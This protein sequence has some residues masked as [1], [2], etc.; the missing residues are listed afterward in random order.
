MTERHTMNRKAT[1]AAATLAT[2]LVPPAGSAEAHVT[3]QPAQAPAGGFARLDVRVPSEDPTNPT[4]KVV[5]QM[6]PGFA[7]ASY[8][9]VPGWKVTVATRKLATPIKTDDGDTLTDELSRLTFTATGHG[10]APGQFQDFGLSLGIPDRPAGTKLTFKALQTYG[11]GTL[12]RW[13]GAKDSE[14]PAPTVQVTAPAGGAA[15]ATP[16]PASAATPAAKAS[17]DSA[18]NGLAVAALIVGALGLITGVAGLTAARRLRA[19]A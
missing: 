12:V 15:S 8:E 10:L 13:I 1:V 9:P 4:K 5:V 6:P 17:S 16:A 19:R 2:A 18:A 3:V 7:D 14:T 11:N